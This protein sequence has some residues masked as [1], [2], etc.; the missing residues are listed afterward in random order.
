MAYCAPVAVVAL[1]GL[2]DG[3]GWLLLQER[4]SLAPTNPD[5]W[6]LVGGLVDQGEQPAV[7]ARRELQ[8]ETGLVVDDLAFVAERTMAC[9]LHGQDDYHLFA[10]TTV[11]VD[12]DV[13]CTEGRQI[14]FVDSARI[15]TLDLT[16]TTRE[17]YPLVLAAVRTP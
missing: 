16:D 1:V 6:S 10:A 7:G 3:R 5:R 12:S 8:E 13:H 14:V 4:D 2:V 11:A 15:A 17:L 9:T